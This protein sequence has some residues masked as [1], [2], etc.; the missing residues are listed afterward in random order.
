MLDCTSHSACI[1]ECALRNEKT[2]QVPVVRREPNCSAK[3]NIAEEGAK[4]ESIV[5]NC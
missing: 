1:T 3:V 5:K 2:G 4:N